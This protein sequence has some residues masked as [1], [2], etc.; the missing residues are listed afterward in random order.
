LLKQ[1][2]LPIDWE[3]NCVLIYSL[4]RCQGLWPL[5]GNPWQPLQRLSA[6]SLMRPSRGLLTTDR[7]NGNEWI[8][9][10]STNT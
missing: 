2:G 10:R 7:M 1:V 5:T 4:Y 8:V 6:V 3:I 9:K